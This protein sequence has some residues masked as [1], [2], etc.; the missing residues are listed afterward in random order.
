[1]QSGSTS[2]QKNKALNLQG[3][4]G[5]AGAIGTLEHAISVELRTVLRVL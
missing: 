2:P 4:L 3:F 1:L 5:C